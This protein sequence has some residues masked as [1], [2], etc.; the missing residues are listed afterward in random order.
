[1]AKKS[2]VIQSESQT[3]RISWY[4]GSTDDCIK[5][6]IEDAFGL[7]PKC[8][9]LLI[10]PSDDSVVAISSSLPDGLRFN[11]KPMEGDEKNMKKKKDSEEQKEDSK[12]SG[13]EGKAFQGELLKFERVNAHLA[14]ERTWLAWI[15]TALAVLSAAFTM[16]GLTD[17]F[18]SGYQLFVFILGCLYVGNV[19]LTYITGWLRYAQ[20]REILGLPGNMIKPKFNRFGLSHQARYLALLL[21]V[22]G[23]SYWFC[24]NHYDED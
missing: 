8:R 10:D 19:L 5:K 2:I 15:R 13:F 7:P 23:V 4:D 6:L 18:S 22:T 9:F 24:L 20:V 17:D 21:L 11:L 1:M 16:L 12:D 3:S 14:N